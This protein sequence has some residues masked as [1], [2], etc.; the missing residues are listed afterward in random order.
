[1]AKVVSFHIAKSFGSLE[2]APESQG[3]E[4]SY[5]PSSD[6]SEAGLKI[7]VPTSQLGGLWATARAFLMGHEATDE[8]L[9][10]KQSNGQ[11]VLIKLY[12][13]RGAPREHS[14][15]H[16][17]LNEQVW[18]RIVTGKSEED[19]RRIRLSQ[20]D[21]MSIDLACTTAVQMAIGG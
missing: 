13:D 12:R 14:E 1:M 9:I 3:L 4:L 15:N 11:E 20:R 19:R 21:L 8:N 5:R 18:L 16:E 6:R 17:S 10:L 2:L 7:T